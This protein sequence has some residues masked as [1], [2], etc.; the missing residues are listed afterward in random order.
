MKK[1]TAESAFCPVGLPCFAAVFLALVLRW[2]A[3]CWRWSFV[4]VFYAVL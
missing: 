4:L 2:G 3:P 1:Y